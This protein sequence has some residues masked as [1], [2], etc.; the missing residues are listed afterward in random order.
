MCLD[1]CDFCGIIM[2]NIVGGVSV[3]VDRILAAKNG[4]ETAFAALC[5]DYAPLIDSLVEK[6]SFATEGLGIDTD[7]LRQE[8]SVAFY[9]ALMSFDGEQNEVTFGLYA[10]ICIRNRM[11]SLL[12][13]LE[14]KKKKDTVSAL[15][16][17]SSHEEP[18]TLPF[19][20]EELSVFT[21]ERLTKKEKLIFD[22]YLAGSSYRE[23]AEAFGL[24]VK[25]VDN[26]LF[27][28]KRK[29]RHFSKGSA[30]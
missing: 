18:R 17:L 30:E 20:K 24:S 26:A 27:R 8:A 10:K 15:R 25:S 21:E 28:A 4:D 1:K 29:L 22:R 23:I 13:H 12:R 5:Q 6:F 2:V 7:D 11:V 19:T 14:A 3:L 9:R 16:A